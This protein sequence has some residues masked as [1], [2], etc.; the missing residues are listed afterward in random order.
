M[1]MYRYSTELIGASRLHWCTEQRSIYQDEKNKRQVAEQLPGVTTFVLIISLAMRFVVLYTWIKETSPQ[2]SLI[3]KKWTTYIIWVAFGFMFIGNPEEKSYRSTFPVATEKQLMRRLHH[4][5]ILA[6]INGAQFLFLK[7]GGGSAA[8]QYSQRPG[9]VLLSVDE[10]SIQS[11]LS[12]PA[13]GWIILGCRRTTDCRTENRWATRGSPGPEGGSGRWLPPDAPW[14]AP[15]RAPGSSRG[16]WECESSPCGSSPTGRGRAGC[17]GQPPGWRR[18]RR[19]SC[20]ERTQRGGKRFRS[21]VSSYVTPSA[22]RS[23]LQKP[24]HFNIQLINN[25]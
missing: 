9:D 8:S 10:M 2:S 17:P 5:N 18:D 3:V 24:S 7:G 12:S 25:F 1:M 6:D 15:A 13:I 19:P 20:P 4:H 16:R 22:N 23:G 11:S 21:R 14:A